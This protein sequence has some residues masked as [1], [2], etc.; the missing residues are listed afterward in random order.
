MTRYIQWV[1]YSENKQPREA[2]EYI[3]HGKQL[4]YLEQHLNDICS[5]AEILSMSS[6]HAV[7]HSVNATQA[8]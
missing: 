3:M 6:V 1:T 4:V 7:T 5:H 2:A 8:K